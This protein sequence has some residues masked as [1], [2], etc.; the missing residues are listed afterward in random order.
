MET[1]HLASPLCWSSR[2][3]DH[4]YIYDA[5]YKLLDLRY[6]CRISNV[7][8]APRIHAAHSSPE[9]PENY[10]TEQYLALIAI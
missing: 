4:Y 2:F 6:I 7:L 1:L 8:T 10:H 3:V 5:I 9:D